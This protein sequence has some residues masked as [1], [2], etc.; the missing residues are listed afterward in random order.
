MVLDG[1]P[2]DRVDLGQHVGQRVIAG[3]DGIDDGLQRN[4][5]VN[6]GM[7]VTI[8]ISGIRLTKPF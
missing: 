4:N 3:Y 1:V 6:K 8:R 5:F 2:I 7:I